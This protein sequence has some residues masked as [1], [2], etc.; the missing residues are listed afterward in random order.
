M[1]SYQPISRAVYSCLLAPG[2][3]TVLVMTSSTHSCSVLTEFLESMDYSA[4]AGQ[5]GTSMLMMKLGR[6]LWWKGRLH[7]TKKA[8]GRG[9]QNAYYRTNTGSSSSTS[10]TNKSSN[11]AGVSEALQRKDKE[12]QER[13]AS[14]R[15]VRGGKTAP[16]PTPSRS[17]STAPSSVV[18]DPVE[19]DLFTQL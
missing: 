2:N 6:Y 9:E 1:L 3:N 11:N 12:R 5:R 19:A 18:N 4:P 8:E 13:A 14:R 10:N 16:A 17:Q 7:Q 15:R